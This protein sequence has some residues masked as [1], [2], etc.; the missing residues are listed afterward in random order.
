MFLWNYRFIKNDR[1]IKKFKNVDLSTDYN[2]ITT[3][4]HNLV[5]QYICPLQC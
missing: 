5:E 3:K 2:I 4:F 1:S